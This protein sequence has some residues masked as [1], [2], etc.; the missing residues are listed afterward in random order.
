[1]CYGACTHNPAPEFKLCMK[2]PCLVSYTGTPKSNEDEKRFAAVF[3]ISNTELLAAPIHR[4]QS[5]VEIERETSEIPLFAADIQ[6]TLGRRGGRQK[7]LWRRS[8][9]QKEQQKQREP[10]RDTWSLA[11]VSRTDPGSCIM[12][13]AL[14]AYTR[15]S[16]CNTQG[17]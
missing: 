16:H 6:Q 12:G 10:A 17:R 13:M 14:I 3:A 9:L 15:A 11:A 4:G 8:K 7:S 5:T 2:S 1:M